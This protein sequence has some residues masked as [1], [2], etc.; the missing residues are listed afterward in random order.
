MEKGSGVDSRRIHPRPLFHSRWISLQHPKPSSVP[1]AS[2]KRLFSLAAL[3]FLSISVFA[4]PNFDVPKAVA[5]DA[6]TLT[7]IE[8]KI[9]DLKVA[10][11]GLPNVL[12]PGIREDLEVY[13]KAA[14]WMV[15]HGEYFAKDTAKQ[16]LAV[17]DAGLERA[18]HAAKGEA[19]WREVRGKPVVRGHYSPVDGSIQPMSV[20]VPAELDPTKPG[21]HIVVVLHGRD[22]TLT[23]VKFISGK[24]N[25]KVGTTSNR[26]VIEVYGRGNN[27]YRWAGEQ[28]VYE[29]I[30]VAHRSA[31]IEGTAAQK[32][33]L[34][35]PVFLRG[36][37]M[38]GAG[39]WHIGLHNPSAFAA[40][41]PGAGFTTTH[42][43]IK[44]LPKL[45]D[46]QE[47]CLTIYDAANYAE[48]AFHV[49]VIAYS[50]EKDP[51][52]A[53]ADNIENAL[54]GF[55]EPLNFQHLVAPG[56]EHKQPQEWLAKIE[57]QFAKI[58]AAPEAVKPE[59]VRFVTYTLRYPECKW[60]TIEGLERHYDRAVV[61]AVPKDGTVTVT[62]QNVSR[63]KLNLKPDWKI[64][65]DGQSVPVSN[66]QTYEKLNGKWNVAKSDDAVV[67]KRP[68]LQGPIDDVF[69]T[70]FRVVG[71]TKAGWIDAHAKASL[72]RF[73]YEWDKYFRGTL[74]TKPQGEQSVLLF[75]DPASNP[76]IAAVLPKLPITWTADKLIVNGVEYDPKTHVP[77]LIYPH[78]TVTGKYV[79]LNSGH[80]FHAAD[81]KGTNALLYPRLGD[82]AVLKPNPTKAD[83]AAADVVAAGIFD[84][85]WRFE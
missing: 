60:V 7:K 81:L 17:L 22:Q 44:N 65:I 68:G 72:A 35:A 49:P 30:S 61:D 18:K 73:G 40:I 43:Y 48:N 78:P 3:L 64:V 23:E 52:K 50:G 69:H 57:E 51:Q 66:S 11:D 41:S 67:R 76:E 82:W 45:P 25:A 70:P 1:G 79:V 39:T 16:T 6:E 13:H 31:K 8:Q 4:Q 47:H 5:I 42:G 80:T 21:F 53:A 54:K 19:P 32:A 75:G 85:N 10:L 37:S 63:I 46:Y 9:E 55:K 71:P 77:V 59:R 28:D 62:T 20:L 2:V 36:F 29:A 26:I 84:E 34:T 12:G 14:V 15:R 58:Q 56:L 27:A 74:P 24:E 83:P 38:G 33:M